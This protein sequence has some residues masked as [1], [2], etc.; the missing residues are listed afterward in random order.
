MFRKAIAA[1]IDDN[2]VAIQIKSPMITKGNQWIGHEIK[3]EHSHIDVPIQLKD[4]IKPKA[5][6][7]IP[8]FIKVGNLVKI[9]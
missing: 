5:A 2:I 8:A 7:K 9:I 3:E 1:N 6:P 4:K